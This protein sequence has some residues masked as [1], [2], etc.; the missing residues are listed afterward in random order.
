MARYVTKREGMHY[1]FWSF[2]FILEFNALLLVA[3]FFFNLNIF[4]IKT[5]PR[6]SADLSSMG[7]LWVF[8]VNTL[9]VNTKSIRPRHRPAHNRV[10]GPKWYRKGVRVWVYPDPP[11]RQTRPDAIAALHASFTWRNCLLLY[12]LV[13]FGPKGYSVIPSVILLFLPFL[14]R[15][16]ERSWTWN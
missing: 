5:R 10:L 3:V 15:Y 11:R 1:F 13:T 8:V 14:P 16:D 2:N 7:K 6:A 9:L 12:C 4:D